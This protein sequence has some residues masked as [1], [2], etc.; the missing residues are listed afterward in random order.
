MNA[1][2]RIGRPP[3]PHGDTLAKLLPV[4]LRLFLDE[5]G[6]ALTPTRLH[7]ESGIARATIYRNWPEPADLIEVMLGRATE[8]PPTELFIGDLEEDLHAAMGTLVDRFLHKP[9]RAFFA[10][11]LEYGRH[12]E[13]VAAASEAF[14]TGILAPLRT[15]IDAALDEG[16]LVGDA[17]ELVAELAG[18][19]ILEHV[20][21]G[22][23]VTHER[24]RALVDHFLAHP[25]S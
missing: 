20:V 25:R 14:V 19:L 24:G 18:P 2:A 16:R 22:R 13:R 10:A 4:A 21:M 8:P 3:G 9:A 6:A 1:P 11:C 23:T 17:D 12:S 5:G 15:V 7:Q